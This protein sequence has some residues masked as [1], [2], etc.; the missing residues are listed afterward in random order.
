M[1]GGIGGNQLWVTR[2]NAAAYEK[3]IAGIPETLIKVIMPKL[4]AVAG[5][6]SV[7]Q[8]QE[9][10]IQ[11]EAAV[12]MSANTIMEA[13]KG[14][15]ETGDWTGFEKKL[16]DSIFN[17]VSEGMIVAVIQSEA[18]S[19]A[20]APVYM[21]ITAA[22]EK[23]MAGESMDAFIVSTMAQLAIANETIAQL[24]PLFDVMSEGL[25]VLSGEFYGGARAEGGPVYPG[26]YYMVGERGPEL[27]A[28]QHSGAIIPAGNASVNIDADALGAAIARRLLPLLSKN[29]IEPIQI[30]L[31]LDGDVL[32]R[33]IY[34]RS[35]S[36][37]PVVHTRGITNV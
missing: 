33:A 26:K 30:N 21:G 23:L 12:Q 4:M 7:E 20:L 14:T 17:S 28:S 34:D 19:R 25:G 10:L 27:F 29:N 13:F 6:A 11:V 16:R 35:K 31:T 9:Y 15:L 22:I 8:F 2:E 18:I 24:K 1:A 36:G 37:R 5:K 32:I 3:Y